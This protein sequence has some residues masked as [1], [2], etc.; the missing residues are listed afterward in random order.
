[1]KKLT[2]VGIRKCDKL[3]NVKNAGNLIAAQT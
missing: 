1:M 2:N 3:D